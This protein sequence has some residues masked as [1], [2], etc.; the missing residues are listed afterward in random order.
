MTLDYFSHVFQ[1]DIDVYLLYLYVYMHT[2]KLKS[3]Y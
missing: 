1:Y 3:E 2:I